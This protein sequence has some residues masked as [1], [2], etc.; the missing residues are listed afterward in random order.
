M[1]TYSLAAV[2]ALGCL[3]C[4]TIACSTS[5]APIGNQC[6]SSGA[7]GCAVDA[8]ERDAAADASLDGTA[9]SPDAGT[10]VGAELDST[11]PDDGGAADAQSLD[12]DP[13]PA[14]AHDYLNCSTSC[15]V[16]S[17]GC[18]SFSC[19]LANG[20]A[21]LTSWQQ[22]PLVIRTPSLSGND[23]AC[24]VDC[25][26]HESAGVFINLNLPTN[27]MGVRISVSPPWHVVQLG[28]SV[29][30]PLCPVMGIP[31]DAGC[32]SFPNMAGLVGVLTDDPQAP[33]R[34]VLLEPSTSS[35]CP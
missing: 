25:G 14:D 7:G 33:S 11:P 28:H 34:N 9:S 20:G 32:F 24:P 5:T 8:G 1:P 12:A 2:S 29:G 19:A 35:Y 18:S 10:D 22:L 16:E 27:G 6:P 15:G 30:T 3:L 23:P 17:P 13:C 4:A 26:T 31:A 21:Q